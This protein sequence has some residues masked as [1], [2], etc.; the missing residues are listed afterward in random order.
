MRPCKRI[1]T[2]HERKFLKM[3]AASLSVN[4][5]GISIIAEWRLILKEAQFHKAENKG[6]RNTRIWVPQRKKIQT[7][8][9]LIPLKMYSNVE[10]DIYNPKRQLIYEEEE[11]GLWSWFFFFCYCLQNKTKP[12]HNRMKI[13]EK[14]KSARTRK[15]K[16]TGWS[17]RDTGRFSECGVLF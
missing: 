3:K 13:K 15:K 11:V 1:D 6:K 8:K 4:G 16:L 7:E 14:I 2:S 5:P 10:R 12:K 17:V 9:F